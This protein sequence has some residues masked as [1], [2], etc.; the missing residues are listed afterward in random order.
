M[1][2]WKSSLNATG[3]FVMVCFH[4]HHCGCNTLRRCL[5]NLTTTNKEYVILQS[6]E[7]EDGV[8]AHYYTHNIGICDL[9]PVC[10]TRSIV[11]P[12]RQS[13]PSTPAPN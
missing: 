4:F 11:S 2:F 7:D 10:R 12:P 1:R 9:A 8:H 3:L 13:G 6:Y 5:E